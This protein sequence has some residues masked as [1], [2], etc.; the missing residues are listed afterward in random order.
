MHIATRQQGTSTVVDVQGDIDLY[1]SP[2]VRKIILEELK[3]KKVPR[4]IVNL[5]GV[6]YIDSSGVASLVEGL[7][8]SRTMSSRFMLY[9][10]SPAAREV[11]ELSR[12][13]RVFEVFAT[14]QEAL[15]AQ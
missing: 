13:I 8:V 14:E 5:S 6:R 15:Q 3:E 1:N 10:L 2:E 12:L 7:K 9:G 4:L 11:L